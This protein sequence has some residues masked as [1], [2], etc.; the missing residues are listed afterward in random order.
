MSSAPKKLK[1]IAAL[2]IGAVVLTAGAFGVARDTDQPAALAAVRPSAAVEAAGS[3]ATSNGPGLER[4]IAS[5]EAR[6]SET[7]KDHTGWATLGLA[8]VQQARVTIDPTLYSRAEDAL[9]TSWSINDDDNDLALAGNSALAAGRHDFAAAQR[10]ATDGL[11]INPYSSLL[12]G[13]LS[14]AQIQLGE[15]DDA[16]ASIQKML[17]LSPDTTSLSRASYAFELRGD[18]AQAEALMER[19]LQD[20][21]TDA[22]RAFALTHLGDLA[23][24]AGD[25][26]RALEFQ[27]RALDASPDDVAAQFGRARAELALGQTETALAHFDDLVR[28]VPDPFYAATYGAALESVG[29][30]EE[31]AAQYDLVDAGHTLFAASG[32]LPDADAVLFDIQRGR[33]DEALVD[34][35]S[36]MDT[37]PFLATRDAYAWALHAAGRHDE[38]L[39]EIEAALALGTRNAQFH[40]HA[41]MIR[42]A[43]GDVDGARADLSEALAINPFFDPID[44]PIA[45]AELAK[46]T[47]S[48]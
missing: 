43:L 17:D 22:D 36:A 13:L 27:L 34:A 21:P 38:A 18:V 25:P 14:D 42:L 5:L 30:V 26:N 4:T 12:Y 29:R 39:I 41:G 48:S 2:G 20:A 33:I 1:L 47:T 24:D 3:V 10:F 37:Q 44:G 35:E 6:L 45:A 16:F 28:R 32:Q 9:A 23:F 40:Y 8:L 11:A 15:Y 7:P 31:A 19:A 46:L